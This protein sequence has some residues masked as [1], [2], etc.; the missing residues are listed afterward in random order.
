MYLDVLVKITE[1]KGKITHKKKGNMTYVNYEVGRE[2]FPDRKYTIP[3]RVIIGKFVKDQDGMMLPNQNFLTY[4]PDE[5]LPEEKMFT[6]RSS[7]IKIGTYSVIEMVRGFD[8]LYRMD[9]AVTKTQKTILKA[10]GVDD[11]YIKERA[12]RIRERL[13]IADG[14]K[15]TEGKE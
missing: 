13:R 5:E 3:K 2:Y 9:H 6:G 7:C 4:F 14:I 8:G 11:G 1:V 10:F 12:K 15:V